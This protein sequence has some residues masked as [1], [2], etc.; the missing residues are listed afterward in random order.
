LNFES[1]HGDVLAT[2]NDPQDLLHRLLA[3]SFTIEPLIAEMLHGHRFLRRC[4]A[5]R[6]ELERPAP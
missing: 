5:R 1:E 6:T 4:L 3:Q 2:V